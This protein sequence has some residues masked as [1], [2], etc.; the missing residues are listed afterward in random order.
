[1]HKNATN[2]VPGAMNTAALLAKMIRNGYA[3]MHRLTTLIQKSEIQ[4]IQVASDG[5][6]VY[7]AG[8]EKAI[9]VSA[10]RREQ[11]KA[12]FGELCTIRSASFWATIEEAR[13]YHETP[14][15]KAAL[16]LWEKYCQELVPF[17]LQAVSECPERKEAVV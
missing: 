16:S 10:E 1:M 12:L 17:V 4:A 7:F 2:D 8:M 11:L 9:E 13:V 5:V 14:H 15:G 6:V 3:E